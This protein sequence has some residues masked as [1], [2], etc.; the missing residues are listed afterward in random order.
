MKLDNPQ[1]LEEV[2][3]G[4]ARSLVGFLDK[5]GLEIPSALIS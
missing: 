1:P 3:D 2:L 4:Y 5:S